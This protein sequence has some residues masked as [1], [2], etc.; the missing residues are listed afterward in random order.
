MNVVELGKHVRIDGNRVVP[1][2]SNK[3]NAL[4]VYRQGVATLVVGCNYV[5]TVTY[6]NASNA[7]L[8]SIERT[9]F[10]A[11]EEDLAGSV[12]RQRRMWE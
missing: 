1:R 10:V 9:V 3:N 8:A 2:L 6:P 5:E 4:L 7:A 11:I 12:G